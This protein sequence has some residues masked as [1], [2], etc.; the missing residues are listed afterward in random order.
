VVRAPAD[1]IVAANYTRVPLA[2]PTLSVRRHLGSATAVCQYT[3]RISRAKTVTSTTRWP[4]SRDGPVPRENC[5]LAHREVN[6]RKG[7]PPPAESRPATSHAPERAFAAAGIA[8]HFA[9][10]HALPIGTTSFG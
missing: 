6:S 2:P 10:P 1:V 3:G 9:N 5:V 8:V 7:Q 4:R